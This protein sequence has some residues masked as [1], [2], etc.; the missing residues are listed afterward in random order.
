MI[1][2]LKH[3]MFRRFIITLILTCIFTGLAYLML[4][5]PPLGIDDAHIFFVYGQHLA[6]GEGFVYNIG[7]EHV[8]GFS[9]LAWTLVITAVYLFTN[10]PEIPLLLISILLISFTIAY[11]WQYI[12]ETQNSQT[13]GILF[14]VMV[15]SSLGFII[16]NTITLMDT[17]L[18]TSLLSL[19]IITALKAKRPLILSSLIALMILTRPEAIVWGIALILVFAA[20]VYL[21]N[22]NH[23][24]WKQIRLPLFTYIVVLLSLICW[25]LLYFGYPLPNT[26][27]AKISPDITY[28]LISGLAYASTFVIA[29]P[30]MT[31]LGVILSIT[32]II[33]NTPWLLKTLWMKNT[34][35]PELKRVRFVLYA[36]LATLAFVLP[37][38]TGGDHFGFLRFYQP[39][40]LIFFLPILF[41]WD[42]CNSI[43][44]SKSK[45]GFIVIFIVFLFISPFFSWRNPSDAK[46][47]ILHEFTIAADGKEIGHLLN[48]IEG[49]P[50][51]IGVIAA[52]GIANTYEGEIFDAMGLNHTGVAHA[53][54]DRIGLK[55]HAAFNSDI[56]MQEKPD[57]F[58][59]F[60]PVLDEPDELIQQWLVTK[61]YQNTLLN[62]FQNYEAFID[63]YQLS[64]IHFPNRDLRVFINYAYL[65]TLLEQGFIITPIVDNITLDTSLSHENE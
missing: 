20:L 61:D 9:S 46:T 2:I 60:Y 51:K 52:G 39:V 65:D 59:S 5:S 3:A 35:P 1:P 23:T 16:W 56:F 50:P 64:I 41:I 33:L 19:G 62:G 29:H 26:Y 57:I 54:G 48:S 37:I 38:W 13:P 53:P 49:T 32:I 14:L 10:S 8:E 21:Q 4:D 43:T 55:N 28:S 12:D 31:T 30:L 36:Y 18:W 45:Y 44:H 47:K 24:A 34:S 11:V 15:Y 63:T 40:W 27:Y 25:R 42:K 22:E 17:A 58:V 6:D 7:S